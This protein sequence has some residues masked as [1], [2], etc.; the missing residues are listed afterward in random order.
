MQLAEGLLKDYYN[1]A[2]VNN[3]KKRTTDIEEKTIAEISHILEWKD[4]KKL[5]DFL[6]FLTKYWAIEIS[7][8]LS[9][10]FEIEKEVKILDVDVK[11][12]ISKLDSLGA[13]KIFDWIVDD[14]YFDLPWNIIENKPY[15]VSFR[16]RFK[17][18]KEWKLKLYYTIKRKMPKDNDLEIKT[19]DCFEKE[20]EILSPDLIMEWLNL[21]DFKSYRRKTKRR[22]AYILSW[23]KFD[24]DIYGVDGVSPWL[25][26]ETDRPDQIPGIMWMLDLWN[27]K[28]SAS[29]SRGTM[30]HNYNIPRESHNI[31]EN[32]ISDLSLPI[33]L[34]KQLKGK[35]NSKKKKNN[36]KK[37]K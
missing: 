19:R 36:K 20:F 13:T 34:I 33:S 29:W 37:K 32:D 1:I 27:H 17:Y 2:K 35:L 12:I 5:R 23:V 15:K 10:E 7:D 9:N 8:N 30:F 24:I 26:I 18:S 6:L 25:E 28:T 11:S 21:V 3:F 31:V 16:I 22:I 14:I 4:L